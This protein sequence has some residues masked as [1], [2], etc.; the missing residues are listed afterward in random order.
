MNTQEIINNRVRALVEL[1][2]AA[3]DESLKYEWEVVQDGVH[4][5]GADGMWVVR[6]KLQHR[7]DWE[8]V[9]FYR[10]VVL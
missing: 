3:L 4:W 5:S 1:H 2:R 7:Y 9:K 10:S 8:T 6:L